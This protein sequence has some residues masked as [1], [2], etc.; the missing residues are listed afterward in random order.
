MKQKTKVL[1]FVLMC[2]LLVVALIIY[3]SQSAKENPRAESAVRISEIMASNKGS[4]A[5]ENGEYYDWVELYN[6]STEAVDISGYGLSDDITSGA[7]FVF[8]QGTKLEASGRIVVWCAGGE[9]EGSLYAPFALSAGESVILY[10]STGGTVDTVITEAVESGNSYALGENGLWSQMLPS[11]GYPNTDEGVSAY[12]AYL[13]ETGE[14]CGVYI[15]EFMASNATTLADSYGNYS[16]WIEL[17]NSNDTEVDLSGYG[18]SDNI[19][20]PKKYVLPEGT[21]IPAKGYLVIFCSG[22]QGFSETGE[23]HAPFKLKAYGEDVVLAS[24]NGSIIDSYSYGLQQTDSSTARSV[25]G[26]GDWQQTSHPTPGYPNDDSGYSQFMATAALPKGDIVI[27]EIMGRNQSAY[28]APDGNYY[29]IIELENTGS[30]PVSLL[31]YALTTNPKNPASYVFGDVTIPAGGYIVVYAKGS[32]ADVKTDGSE[33][34]CDFGINKEGDSVYLFDSSGVICDKL[35]AASFL[36]NVSYGR[37]STGKLAYFKEPTVGA[38]NGTGY[39]GITAVPVFSKTPGVYEETIQIEI[40]VPEGET[41][42]YTLD[43]TTP[44]ENSPVY[45]GPITAEKN[46]VIRAIS[47]REGYITNSVTSG[48]FLFTSDD[49]DH[50]LPIVTLVTDPDNL[51]DEKTGIYAYGENYDPD[52]PYAQL[53]TTANYYQKDKTDA[54]AWER[55]ANFALFDGDTK[56]QV[57]NQNIGIRIAGSFGRG[58]AQKGFNIIARDEYGDSRMAYK[59][60]DNRDYTEYKALV[61]RAGAQDQNRSKIRDELASG[62]LEGTDVNFLYQA[63]RPCVLY[64][65][66]EYWGV[67]F[68]KEKRNRFFV[69]QHEGTDDTESMIIAKGYKQTTYGNV[70]EWVTFYDTASKMDLSVAENYKYV[71]D[72]MD[73]DSFMDYMIAEIYTGNTDTYNIQCYKLPG[74]KWKWIYYD[75]CWGFQ[76]VTHQTL[77]ARMGDTGADVA[78]ARLF[79]ALLG[80]S[81]WKDKFVRRFAELL[82]TAFAPERVLALI[83]ELYGY[84]QPEIAREREKFNSETF[85]GVKQPSEVLGTYQSFENEIAR[86]KE[87]AEK[88]PEELKKQLQSVLGLSDSYMAEVFG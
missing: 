41:V 74:G 44:D 30:E 37:D 49:V 26:T 1:F 7:K 40:Q 87:F 11:P 69:A 88:R 73:V 50:S 58:R 84:V 22:N 5:D 46:T 13:M 51:W 67:Y 78:S 10:N 4:V 3:V 86:I 57:F 14:D 68:L 16:D 38:A 81:E 12:E 17:Y 76:S 83:D 75:F 39:E 72:N 55:E 85:M 15:N 35:Q 9:H 20:Q 65:N 36:P 70:S 42:H 54:R 52:L 48:T 77:A 59:F 24:R 80:N 79:K 32:G 45:T 29:D 34:C 82:N 6:S 23:L 47:I 28:Q 8:P 63:Y 25:D 61:L 21:V 31:G 19:A 56:Q 64:L 18:I 71:T 27:S 2:V 43:C 33:L 66:G 62:L 60:F 53:L